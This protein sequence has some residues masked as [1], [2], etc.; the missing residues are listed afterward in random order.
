MMRLCAFLLLIAASFAA[1]PSSFALWT[2]STIGEHEATLMKNVSPDHSSLETP[3]DYGDHRFRLLYRDADGLPEEH[4]KI[5]DVVIVHSGEGVRR[6]AN[7]WGRAH[8]W[9]VATSRCRRYRPH[10]GGHP[11]PLS[12]AG[13]QAHYL[14]SAEIPRETAV[15]WLAEFD[16]PIRVCSRAQIHP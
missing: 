1:D 6:P 16:L 14:R 3:A 10:S 11:A 12:C 2:R 9:R 15:I 8:W 5:V 4:D 13:R 7:I